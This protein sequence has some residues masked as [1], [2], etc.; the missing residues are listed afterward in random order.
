MIK[1]DFVEPETEEW[2]EWVSLC[3]A[4]TEAL[5]ARVARGEEPNITDLY[6]DERMKRVYVCLQAPFFCKCAYCEA[7][8]GDQ[9]G[10]IEHFRPKGRV[11]DETG[12][13]VMVIAAN[14]ASAAHPGYYWLAYDWRNLLYA[15]AECNRP[16][17]FKTAGTQIGKWEKFPVRGQ[18]AS[19]P[20]EEANEAPLLLNPVFSDPKDHLAIDETGVLSDRTEEGD[21][22]IRILG[23][24]L[25]QALVQL[26]ADAIVDT[27]NAI[28]AL[29]T[30][31]VRRDVAVQE[32]QLERMS[33]IRSGAAPF[34]MACRFALNRARMDLASLFED[35]GVVP[36][37]DTRQE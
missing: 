27:E 23:L 22:C 17:S 1:I 10:D 8:L 6:K 21:T 18:H 3:Q 30:A 16:S 31:C 33:R 25:R 35:L 15:C 37:G 19:R 24:N 20:G 14:G 9:P 36:N 29:V 28:N 7:L 13:T 4:E 32:K 5:I 11:T 2:K 26:R 34:A 12:N